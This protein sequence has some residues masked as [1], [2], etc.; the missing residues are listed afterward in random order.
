MAMC[1]LC[2][3]VYIS[4]MNTKDLS[5]LREPFTL[6]RGNCA[7]RKGQIRFSSDTFAKQRKLNLQINET[8][9]V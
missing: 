6:C 9:A 1:R 3:D 2:V 4:G 8:G 5:R 7:H